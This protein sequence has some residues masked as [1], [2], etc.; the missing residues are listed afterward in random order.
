MIVSTSK[1]YIGTQLVEQRLVRG[2]DRNHHL[3]VFLEINE[4]GNWRRVG[5]EP[6]IELRLILNKK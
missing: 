4:E 2:Q 5:F 3:Q 1:V 6:E